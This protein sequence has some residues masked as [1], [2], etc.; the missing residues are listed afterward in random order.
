ME[1]FSSNSLLR[2]Q[3][4]ER[5]TE[6]PEPFLKY[7]LDVALAGTML[8]VGSPVLLLIAI[9][10][11]REDGGPVL[12]EQDRWGRGGE[13]FRVK[14]FRT[15]IPDSDA[16]YGIR[17]AAKNDSRITRIGKRLRAMGLDELPQ[18]LNI[19]KG[20]MSFVGPRA[21]AIGEIVDDGK[22]NMVTVEQ[23]PGFY[24]R[25]AVKP[26]LTS[27][28][29]IYLAKDT[30][31]R[32]KFAYDTLYVKNQSTALDLRLIALSF[33]ISFRGKWESRSEKL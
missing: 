11:N 24:E 32:T 1:T 27:L 31:P 19:L 4:R 12:Y 9:L 21:L 6:Q 14:K 10:I 20:E 7:P 8:V 5:V 3:T 33:W 17:Q 25:L 29:T 13:T 2:A 16:K 30:R 28:A 18:L 26:G 22:G 15:M 23:I